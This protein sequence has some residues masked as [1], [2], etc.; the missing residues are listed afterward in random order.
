MFELFV[1]SD[2]I[3]KGVE[4]QFATEFENAAAPRFRRLRALAGGARRLPRAARA[5]QWA[6]RERSTA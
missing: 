2:L 5:R 6:P 3:R 4:R 1:N